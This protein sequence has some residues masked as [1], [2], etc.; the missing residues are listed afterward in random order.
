MN[1]Y[2][3]TPHAPSLRHSSM[4]C[5]IERKTKR[6]DRPKRSIT[7]TLSHKGRG[8]SA[9]YPDSLDLP[10]EIDAGM[11]VHALAHRLAQF[12]D[13]GR[14]GIAEIDEKIAMQLGNLRI[15]DFQS[16]AAG[17]IDQLPGLLPGGIFEGRAAGAA[18]DRLRRLARFGDLVHL[19]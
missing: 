18:L 3:E 14:A 11:I 7:C 9:S 16:A 15:I 13:V 2:K 4:P 1:L 6:C 17:G 19:G 12:L 5:G 8:V 10:F